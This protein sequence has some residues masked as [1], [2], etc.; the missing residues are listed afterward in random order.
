MSKEIKDEPIVDVEQAFSKTELFIENNKK[1]LVLI[2]GAIAVLVG[3]YFA[4][5][6]WYV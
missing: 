6:Y 3:G 2:I 1:S 5:K 4:Y